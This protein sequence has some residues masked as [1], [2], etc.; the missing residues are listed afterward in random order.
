MKTFINSFA[1]YLSILETGA[2]TMQ[3]VVN[4]DKTC[5]VTFYN[6]ASLIATVNLS[7]INSLSVPL[8][9]DYLKSGVLPTL[10]SNKNTEAF[11]I[12]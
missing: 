4:E 2:N 7:D 6:D 12:F 11:L 5:V 1:N 8:L 3:I 9:D 10:P